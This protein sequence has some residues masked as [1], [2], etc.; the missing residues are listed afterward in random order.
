MGMLLKSLGFRKSNK[1]IYK[2]VYFGKIFVLKGKNF[3][4][5][6]IKKFCGL[7]SNKK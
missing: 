2:K 7:Y 3:R 5:I 1:D 4:S 6:Q